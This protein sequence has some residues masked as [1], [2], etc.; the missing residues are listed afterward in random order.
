[1]KFIYQGVKILRRRYMLDIVYDNLILLLKKNKLLSNNINI[2]FIHSLP[3]LKNKNILINN[4]KYHILLNF[5]VF[6]DIIKNKI[7]GFTFYLESYNPNKMKFL[8]KI[9]IEKEKKFY[10][11]L[12]IDKPKNNINYGNIYILIILDNIGG[13]YLKEENYILKIKKIILEIRQFSNLEIQIRLHP[14]NRDDN[15]IKNNIIKNFP[16][17]LFNDK[18]IED[19]LKDTYLFITQHSNLAYYYL[20][21]SCIVFTFDKDSL[22]YNYIFN[23]KDL[24]IIKD[25]INFNFK[26][27]LLKRDILFRLLM[28]QSI[29]YLNEYEKIF[30]RKILLYLKNY[31]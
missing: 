19:N 2:F 21:H 6:K 14:K 29:F 12:G 18:K 8:G 10:K 15:L 31:S 22:Y 28:N 4:N 16:N 20:Y 26:N 24:F 30:T 5:F 9:S 7:Q 27:Y 3:I 13:W 23:K 1:M 11:N 25:L 17:I